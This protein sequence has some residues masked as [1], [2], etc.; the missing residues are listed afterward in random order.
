M[1]NIEKCLLGSGL[2]IFKLN[3]EYDG[4]GL[5]RSK[6]T[7]ISLTPFTGFLMQLPRPWER[8]EIKI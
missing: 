6:L 2:A 1:I 4:L 5:E 7:L 3:V 8:H